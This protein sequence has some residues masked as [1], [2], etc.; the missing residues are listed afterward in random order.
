MNER[1]LDEGLE[2]ARDWLYACVFYANILVI[3]GGASMAL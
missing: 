1:R 3:C 2:R